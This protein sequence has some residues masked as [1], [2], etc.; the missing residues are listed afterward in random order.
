[1]SALLEHRESGGR[2]QDS[3][4]GLGFGV[5]K[6]K[7]VHTFSSI[8]DHVMPQSLKCTDS[9]TRYRLGF[10]ATVTLGDTLLC[11]ATTAALGTVAASYFSLLLL[12]SKSGH[13]SVRLTNSSSQWG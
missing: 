8:S 11:A 2:A 12:S 6:H 3:I 13:S 10:R 9:A 1:M 4:E 7:K 5:H